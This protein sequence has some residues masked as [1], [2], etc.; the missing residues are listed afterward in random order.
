VVELDLEAVFD[1]GNHDRLMPRLK[2]HVPDTALLRLL[3]RSR[4]A[5]V[6][7]GD[8]PA[9]PTMGVP[10]GGP[11]SPV[12]STVVLAALDGELDRRGHR[13]AR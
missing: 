9:A 12:L 10:P 13:L 8:H 4:K 3:N 6:Y 7:V 1:R 2:Q 11:R 5:G